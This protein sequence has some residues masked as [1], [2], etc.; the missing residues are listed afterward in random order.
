MD[1]G[2]TVEGRAIEAGEPEL[3]LNLHRGYCSSSK[4][5][6][7]WPASWSA[8]CDIARARICT[9]AF[10]GRRIAPA[11]PRGFRYRRRLRLTPPAYTAAGSGDQG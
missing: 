4:P 1:S 10:L 7:V 6:F 5:R 3:R 9:T 2:T 11:G 8:S